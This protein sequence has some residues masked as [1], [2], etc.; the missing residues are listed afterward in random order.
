MRIEFYGIYTCIL[1]NEMPSTSLTSW[2]KYIGTYRIAMR[3]GTVLIEI[4][5]SRYLINLF[6]R[7][8]I[9]YIHNKFNIQLRI[10][11]KLFLIRNRI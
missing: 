4:L 2:I 1:I 10:I 8:Y 6:A 11:E 9:L 7:K 5:R 3:V